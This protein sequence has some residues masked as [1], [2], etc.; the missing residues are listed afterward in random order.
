MEKQA[1]ILLLGKTDCTMRAQ[2]S[3]MGLSLVKKI[4][5][6]FQ[7]IVLENNRDCILGLLFFDYKI[8]NKTRMNTS[9]K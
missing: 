5:E 3:K 8:F 1:R 2:Q 7:C 6:V 9:G 4:L